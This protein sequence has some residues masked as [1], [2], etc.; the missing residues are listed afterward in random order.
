MWP[1]RWERVHTYVIRYVH[2][3]F[4]GI[5]FY[6][7][8]SFTRSLCMYTRRRVNVWE[9]ADKRNRERSR[10]LPPCHRRKHHAARKGCHTWHDI[11]QHDRRRR[12]PAAVAATL[13]HARAVGCRH[14]TTRTRAYTAL[15]RT[16]LVQAATRRTGDREWPDSRLRVR[17]WRRRGASRRD[18][19]PLRLTYIVFLVKSF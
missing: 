2:L 5:L 14:A 19:P 11:A 18:R 13:I 4:I 6:S 9:R 12:R 10:E 1:G 17:T 7:S 15:S 16:S 8:R 3:D